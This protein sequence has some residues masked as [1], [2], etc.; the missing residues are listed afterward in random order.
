M[1]V[2]P[3][4][5]RVEVFIN[6]AGTISIRQEGIGFDDESII[7]VPESQVEMLVNALRAT[8]RELLG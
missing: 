6:E 3:T 5:Y 8:K 2:F 7:A 1:E 4:T